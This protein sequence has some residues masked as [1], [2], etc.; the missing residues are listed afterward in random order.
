MWNMEPHLFQ[1]SSC[2][3]IVMCVTV[4]IDIMF[5]NKLPFSVSISRNIKFCTA[6]L[7][8]DQKHKTLTK[9]VRD[10]RATYMKR[11]FRPHKDVTH[12]RCQFEVLRVYLAKFQIT[13][14]TVA[15]GEHIPEVECHIQT[16]R[17]HTRSV[18]NYLPF[19]K[20]PGRMVVELI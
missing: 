9:A 20:I 3:I 10:V 15:I 18:Y 8:P 7:I 19:K 4:A 6:Q 16:I 5:V 2:C 1:T 17:E 11:G 12:G 13:L 14:N